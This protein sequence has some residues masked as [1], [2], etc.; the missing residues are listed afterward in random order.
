MR[1]PLP[2]L[3]TALLCAS[4]LLQA[5][6]TLNVTSTEQATPVLELFT[7]QG[8]SSCPPAEQ[9]LSSLTR[10]P[11][12]WTGVIPLAFHVDYWDNLGWADTFANPGYSA[13]QRAYE[14]S[15]GSRSVYTPGFILAGNEWR[16]WFGGEQLPLPSTPTVGKLNLQLAGNQVRLSFAAG[17]NAPTGLIAHVARLGFGLQSKIG[18][19]ENAGK[20][21]THDFV[22]LTVQQISANSGNQWQSQLQA[23]PRGER[24]ALVAWLSAPGN[25]APY[26]A[27]AGWLPSSAAIQP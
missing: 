18:H 9:W 19:G 2:C 25:P 11:E 15:G 8:C 23:D 22:V 17:A 5:A 3:F 20:T 21:L 13:R 12:L 24:Q 10:A 16:G 7:S 14:Q 1:Y 27:V 26:Q 6:E 4:S